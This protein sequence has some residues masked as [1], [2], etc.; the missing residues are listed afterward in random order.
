MYK[1]FKNKYCSKENGIY[2]S[3][4][5]LFWLFLF[6]SLAG[7]IIEGIFCVFKYGHWET[8]V[9]SVWGPLCIIYGLGAAGCYSMY[10]ILKDKGIFTQFCSFAFVG[11]L[12]ELV[13]GS[14]MRNKLGMKA[15]TYNKH[16]MNYKGIVS[17]KMT[18][19]WGFIGIAF[20][21]LIPYIEKMFNSMKSAN[22]ALAC[23]VLT[24]VLIFDFAITAAVLVRWSARHFDI[25]AMN[26]FEQF[27]NYKYD[28][29]FMEKRFCEWKFLE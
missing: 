6:G 17:L 24:V 26:K 7:V 2:I 9:V 20:T 3:Y 10:V 19:A 23:K 25:P 27:L 18:I 22:W 4:Q 16:F 14:I 5:R 21:F 29:S 13:C 1:L 28:D 12:L 15:W 8:H 11:F